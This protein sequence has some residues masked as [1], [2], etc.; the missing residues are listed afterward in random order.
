[1]QADSQQTPSVQKPV[2]HSL[3][4]LQVCAL[5]FLHIPEETEQE[6]PG[7]QTFPQEPQLRLVAVFVSQPFVCLLP[8]QSENP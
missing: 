2:R 5:T 8:S 3:F 6:V 7:L 4:A 1:L